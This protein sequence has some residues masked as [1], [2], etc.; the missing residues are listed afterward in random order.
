MQEAVDAV[1]KYGTQQAAADALGLPKNTFQ[2]RYRSGIRAG[3]DEAIV[4]PAPQGHRVKGVSTLYNSK[5]DVTAQWVKTTANQIPLEELIEHLQGAFQDVQPL[6]KIKRPA[7]TD[8]DLLAVYL[9]ADWHIGLLAWARETG[10]DFDIKIAREVILGAM[11]KLILAT[12]AADE[13][14]VLGLGDMLHFD[15]Y[16]PITARSHNQ[17][18]TDSRYPK[19]LRT[20]ADMIV[21]TVEMALQRHKT[22]RVR[23]LAGNHDDS[24]AIALG[25][26]LSMYFT[27]HDRVIVDDSPSRFFWHRAGK[28]FIG[29]TH[30]DK[31]KM[32]DLPLVMA[33][34]RPD[35]WAASTYRRIFCGHFHNEMSI[36][37]GGVI[38][39]TMRSPVARD[40]YHSFAKYRAG[41]SVYSETFNIDGSQ[42]AA[43]KINL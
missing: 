15:G 43:V 18:D 14:I 42:A 39:T 8:A 3:L 31:T 17:L 21:A 32:K 19:V 10:E 36:E 13:A 41:R 33:H 26:A 38:V 30:G 6:R 37:E 16:E 4:H 2:H 1:A 11:E 27:K 34:D 25:I 20:A 29:A 12:P 28:V 23:I 24:A 7:Q 5:G 9:L 40:A 35:D 22:V